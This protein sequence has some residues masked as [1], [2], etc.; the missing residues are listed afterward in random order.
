[1]FLGDSITAARTYGEIIENYTLLRFPARQVRFYN[2]GWGG[3]T[4]AGGAAR[5]QRDVFPRQPT[6]LIVAYGMNDIGWGLR[7]D[8]QHK[9][10]YL[11][12]IRAIIRDC[13]QRQ[14]RV[15]VCSA[16]ITAEEPEKAENGFLQRMCDEGLALAR[17]LGEGA[18]DVQRA[19]REVQ[20]RVLR[21]NQRIEDSARH[22]RLH[23]ADGVHLNDLG[24]LAMAVA[25]LKGLGAPSEVSAVE[26]DAA[27]ERV[28]QATGCE[29]TELRAAD[30]GLE[31]TR[32]DAGLPI[33]FGLFGALN[34]RFVPVH[35]ELNRYLLTVRNL[36][37]GR[38][39]LTADKRGIATYTSE[40][41]ARGVNISSATTNAWQPGGP[42][43]AQATSLRSLTEARSRLAT[44]E[45][46]WNAHLQG[47]P[48]RPPLASDTA[49]IDEQLRQLQRQV[50]RP[51]PYRLRL[52][53]KAD[54]G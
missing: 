48:Q 36:P 50:A 33:N 37:A 43:D 19:M 31:F 27:A 17:E 45:L 34:F 40:Q 38:Y 49:A 8:E 3:D 22:T 39:E 23:A 15:F 5:L 4:A 11:A 54:E 52:Q 13:Q 20:R 16:A 29:V 26:I 53:R 2:V 14:V 44:A 32:L 30:N 51:M 12:A 46:L 18:I 9:Q 41:L 21:E 6:V 42:W 24:Q 28:V 47:S 7:A 1:M 25:I 10:Q 35:N